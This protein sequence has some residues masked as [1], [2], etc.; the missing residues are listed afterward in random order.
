VFE[1]AT[2]FFGERLVAIFEAQ[3]E[4]RLGLGKDLPSDDAFRAPSRYQV[5]RRKFL[6]YA[7]GGRRL[8]KL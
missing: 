1:A 7:N 8:S 3:P 2:P 5:E 6:D 4:E